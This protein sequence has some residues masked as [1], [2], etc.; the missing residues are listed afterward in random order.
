MP[1]DVNTQIQDYAEFF[2][3]ES[4]PITIEEI[5]GAFNSGARSQR[6]SRFALL[7]PPGWAVGLV[8]AAVVVLFVGGFAW[9]IR[10]DGSTDPA[11][12]STSVSLPVQPDEQLPTEPP[13]SASRIGTLETFVAHYNADDVDSLMALFAEES[14]VI[15]HPEQH[16]VGAP[17]INESRGLEAIRELWA[18]DLVGSDGENPLTISSVE[19]TADTVVWDHT[20]VDADGVRRCAYGNVAEIENG[21]I[22]SW[23]WPATAGQCD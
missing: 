5:D 11:T 19:V 9:L 10:S 20:Y 13:D 8:A 16:L 22:V 14:V 12:P 18:A 4:Q 23:T 6:E 15:G 21:T 1:V 3:G 7:E 2:V 17:F